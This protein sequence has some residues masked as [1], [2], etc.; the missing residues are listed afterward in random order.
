MNIEEIIGSLGNVPR[1]TPWFYVLYGYIVSVLRK[2]G[3]NRTIS[4]LELKMPIRTLRLKFGNMEVLGFVVPDPPDTR[5]RLSD[6]R[7]DYL[8]YRASFQR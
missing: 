4:A 2:N 3:G 1:G 7:S 6:V 5:R 8:R